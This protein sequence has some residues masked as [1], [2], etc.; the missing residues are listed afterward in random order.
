MWTLPSTRNPPPATKYLGSLPSWAW[1]SSSGYGSLRTGGARPGSSRIAAHSASPK[2]A[3][4]V[5]NSSELSCLTY[6]SR[7][8]AQAGLDEVDRQNR[9]E[10]EHDQPGED[11]P[12]PDDCLA[13]V[14]DAGRGTDVAVARERLRGGD[15]RLVRF[16]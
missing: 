10:V 5:R 8:S 2:K 12:R 13:R 15:R 14:P 9:G 11:H 16:V 7:G 1:I 6:M 3:R 4:K